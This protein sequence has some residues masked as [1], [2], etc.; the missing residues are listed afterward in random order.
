[1]LTHGLV[2]SVTLGYAILL[3]ACGSGGDRLSSPTGSSERHPTTLSLAP[4]IDLSGRWK[5]TANVVQPKNAGTVFECREVDDITLDLIQV[6][7]TLTGTFTAVV[8]HVVD[9]LGGF[10]SD[11]GDTLVAALNGTVGSG[12]VSFTA[13]GLTVT[14]TFTRNSMLLE[15]SESV[16]GSGAA[17]VQL[18]R[19]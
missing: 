14:G 13:G 8:R 9:N 2:L 11:V 17:G 15:G 19:V 12:T 16:F 4:A 18:H 6:G 3:A 7:S 10:C 1:M 5:G